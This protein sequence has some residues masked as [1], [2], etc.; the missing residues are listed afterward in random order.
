MLTK[1]RHALI[2]SRLA[3]NG[4]VIAKSLANE[5]GLSEDSIRRDLRELAHEGKL[6]R[7][8]GG[9]LPSAIAVG[10]LNVRINLDTA[11]KTLL[12]KYA[13]SLIQNGQV[14]IV[15]GGTS[16]LMMVQQLPAELSA[17]IVTHSPTIASALQNH[18]HIE[19]IMLGGKLFKH[20]MVNMG[21]NTIESARK[22]NADLYFIGAT[23]VH[24]K[25]GL[26]TGDFEEAQV[27]RIFHQQAA[28]TYLMAAA[29]KIGAASAF[30]IT[31]TE[32]ISQI[33]YASQYLNSAQ[34][35]AIQAIAALGLNIHD[36]TH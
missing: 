16:T 1:Q 9:A 22:I 26:T 17:T 28:E 2:L 6:Q 4:E 8:H 10:N 18:E 35:Q 21:A 34:Q 33:L 36:C 29:E 23:G 19:V 3:L 30:Q 12:S 13:A 14:V 25:N 5:L 11:E 15:D 31:A 32:N 27:K 24:A 7:V 20:S